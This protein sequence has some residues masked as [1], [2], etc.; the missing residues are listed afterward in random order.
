MSMYFCI[1]SN[2]SAL[3]AG[4]GIEFNVFFKVLFCFS[5]W[6]V[7]NNKITNNI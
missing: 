5:W 6:F 7:E 2:K 4:L 1:F 3:A